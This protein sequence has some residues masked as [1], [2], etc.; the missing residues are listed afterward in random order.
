MTTTLSH[1]CQEDGVHI[2]GGHQL[3]SYEEARRFAWALL[4]DVDPERAGASISAEDLAMHK[5]R[6]AYPLPPG[7]CRLLLTLLAATQPLHRE[8]LIA[9][10]GSNGTQGVIDVYVCHIRRALGANAI[11]SVWGNGYVLTAVGRSRV[12]EVLG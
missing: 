3:V 4:A 8:R 12:K 2:S 5:L 10:I 9:L 6:R 1:R 7:A 11:E